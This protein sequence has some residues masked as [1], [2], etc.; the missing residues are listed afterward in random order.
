MPAD[1]VVVR[2][3]LYNWLHGGS[4]WV[5]FPICAPAVRSVLRNA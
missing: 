1:K 5:P 3:R 2:R 4:I